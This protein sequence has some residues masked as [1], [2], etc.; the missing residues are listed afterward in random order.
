ELQLLALDLHDVPAGIR[1]ALDFGAQHTDAA[2]PALVDQ[3]GARG[4][5]GLEIDLPLC[6]LIGAAPGDDRQRTVGQCIEG[7]Q[8][9][10]GHHRGQDQFT[11]Q[12]HAHPPFAYRYQTLVHGPLFWRDIHLEAETVFLPIHSGKARPSAS[13]HPIT[14]LAPVVRPSMPRTGVLTMKSSRPSASRRR[15]RWSP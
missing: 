1:V 2:I 14:T 3:L 8:T 10:A 5:E 6:I 9:G 15:R 7:H 11:P 4:L 13:R 12:S